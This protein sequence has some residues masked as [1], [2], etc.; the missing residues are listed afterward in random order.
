MLTIAIIFI[1]FQLIFI[2][3]IIVFSKEPQYFWLLGCI[4]TCI[5]I[6]S[7]YIGFYGYKK[8]QIDAINGKIEYELKKNENNTVHWKKIKIE[9]K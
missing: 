4:A 7:I 6:S 8:G 1:I 5:M 2:T 9:E 3:L